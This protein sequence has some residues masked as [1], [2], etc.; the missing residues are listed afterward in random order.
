MALIPKCVCV[1]CARVYIK[2]NKQESKVSR[3]ALTSIAAKKPVNGTKARQKKNNN[4]DESMEN[5]HSSEMC[6][7]FL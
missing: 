5:I 7:N 4:L 6:K 2:I 1:G 3:A